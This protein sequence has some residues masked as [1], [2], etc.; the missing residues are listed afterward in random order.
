MTISR[1]LMKTSEYLTIIAFIIGLFRYKKIPK[2]LIYIFYFVGLGACTEL[3]TDFYKTFLG[4][5]T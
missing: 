2:D 4:R 1:I 3:F 5:N